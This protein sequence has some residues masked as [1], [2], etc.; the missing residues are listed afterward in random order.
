LKRNIKPGIITIRFLLWSIGIFCVSTAGSFSCDQEETI[1]PCLLNEIRK[2]KAE[3]VRNPPAIVYRYSYNGNSVF[4]IPAYC[5]DI[6]SQ[7]ID[8]DC[9]FICSPDGGISGSGDNQC[10]DFFATR[11]NQEIIWQDTR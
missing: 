11:T 1:P 9:K 4:F 10:I 7:L 8:S 3:A 2:I 6:P 5:C